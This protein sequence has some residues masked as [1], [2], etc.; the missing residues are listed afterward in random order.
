MR[1]STTIYALVKRSVSV[2]AGTI[3]LIRCLNWVLKSFD[4]FCSRDEA[5]SM[6]E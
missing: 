6:H 2:D 4:S 3:F 1:V 5:K